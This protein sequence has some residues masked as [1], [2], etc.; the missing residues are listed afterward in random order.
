MFEIISM[1]KPERTKWI[2]KVMD[3]DAQQAK[4]RKEPGELISQK[5]IAVVR[6][7]SKS[8]ENK[9]NNSG[10]EHFTRRTAK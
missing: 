3:L 2:I 5:V 6:M 8:L 7:D 9:K 4:V 10:L 1:T